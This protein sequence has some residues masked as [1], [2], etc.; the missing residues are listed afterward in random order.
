[1]KHNRFYKN[2][3]RLLIGSAIIIAVYNKLTWSDSVK[4]PSNDAYIV[5]VA[6]NLGIEKH[7]VTQAQF[8]NRYK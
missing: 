6:F 4:N 7:E 1:M 5:E 8:N 3:V 2:L